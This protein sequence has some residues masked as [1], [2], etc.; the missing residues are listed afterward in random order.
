MSRGQRPNFVRIFLK[1]KSEINFELLVVNYLA[2]RIVV[3]V[4]ITPDPRRFAL[5]VPETIS[6]RR[7]I[8]PVI[9][10]PFFIPPNRADLIERTMAWGWVDG[11]N[12]TPPYV[13][14]E[15]DYE[16]PPKYH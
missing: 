12:R 6:S 10:E 16:P 1:A 11:K 2:W 13:P 3:L 14:C 4:A 7:R 9:I 5:V 8:S 15:R